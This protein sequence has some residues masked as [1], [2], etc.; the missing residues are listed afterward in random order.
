MIQILIVDS[1]PIVRSGLELFLNSKPDFKV[2]G[3]L[4]SGI[5]I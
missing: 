5:E 4:K 1:H 2:V 3:K